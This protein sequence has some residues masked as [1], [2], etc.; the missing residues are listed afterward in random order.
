MAGSWTGRNCHGRRND[1][2]WGLNQNTVKATCTRRTPRPEPS[3]WARFNEAVDDRDHGA[4]GRADRSQRNCAQLNAG[5]SPVH[6]NDPGIGPTHDRRPRSSHNRRAANHDR[7][8]CANHDCASG[9]S[10]DRARGERAY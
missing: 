2:G 10:D 5:T 3:S 1:I 4:R 8:T 6:P 7:R 9:K